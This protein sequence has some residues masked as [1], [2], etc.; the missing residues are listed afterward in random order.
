MDGVLSARSFEMLVQWLYISKISFGKLLT[1]EIITAVIEFVR[2]ADMYKVT[3]MEDLMAERIKA[4]IIGKALTTAKKKAVPIVELE[5]GHRRGS[6]ISSYKACH[7]NHHS[8]LAP[9]FDQSLAR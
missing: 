3:G 6:A 4:M 2:L 8:F 1:E 9:L 7:S 5:V